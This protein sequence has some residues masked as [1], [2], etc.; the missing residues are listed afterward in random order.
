[1]NSKDTTPPAST[2]STPIDDRYFEDYVPGAVHRFGEMRVTAQEIIEFARRYDP[3][4]FHTDPAKAADTQFGGLIASGWM[5]CGMMMRMY[6]EHYLTHNASLA[7]P[8]IDELRWL[9]PVRPDDVLSTR[10][11]IVEARRSA[12]KPDRGL[13][14]SKIEVLNQHDRVVLSMLAMNLI[15]CRTPA[16]A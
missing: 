5:T 9:E 13:V 8:G 1:M 15:G 7:S 16:A 4:D 12:S 3:Q 2:F 14:R 11:T 10:V 6:S